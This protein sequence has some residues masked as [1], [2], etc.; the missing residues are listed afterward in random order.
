MKLKLYH[1]YKTR[2]GWKAIAVDE[3]Q[4]DFLIAH[5]KNEKCQWQWGDTGLARNNGVE[6]DYDIIEEWKE[7]RSFDFYVGF[8]ETSTGLYSCL[9]KTKDKLKDGISVSESCGYKI[10]AVKNLV[11]TEGEFDE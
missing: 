7:P 6:T 8:Y 5:T 4:G 10:I 2:G 3:H 11:I 9:Y 1:P